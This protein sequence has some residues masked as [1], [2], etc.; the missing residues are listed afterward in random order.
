MVHDTDQA[1]LLR[2][3]PSNSPA[4]ET[5]GPFTAGPDGGWSRRTSPT[6]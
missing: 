4:L 1:D 3:L 5:G 6:P 2:W